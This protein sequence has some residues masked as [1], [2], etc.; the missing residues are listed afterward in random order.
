MNWVHKQ[1][2]TFLLLVAQ[3]AASDGAISATSDCFAIMNPTVTPQT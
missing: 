2:G 1:S 3:A